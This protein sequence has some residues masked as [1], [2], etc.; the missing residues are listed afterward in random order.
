MGCGAE[1]VNADNSVSV[2]DL[3]LVLGGYGMEECC[4]GAAAA[5]LCGMVDVND[6]CGVTV[7]DLLLVLGM[8]GREC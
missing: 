2:A 8:Y 1:D 7:A 4:A 6:D 3:L 5:E